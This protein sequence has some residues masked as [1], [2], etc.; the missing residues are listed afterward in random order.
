MKEVIQ[1]II[2]N[3]DKMTVSLIWVVTLSMATTPRLSK[4]IMRGGNLYSKR[5]KR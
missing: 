3:M 2:Q 5:L 1:N 4:A